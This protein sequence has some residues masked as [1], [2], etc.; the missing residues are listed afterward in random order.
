MSDATDAARD[1]V[2]KRAGELAADATPE[3]LKTIAEAV[4]QVHYGPQGAANTMRYDY[5]NET[6][7]HN[8]HHDGQRG[9]AGFGPPGDQPIPGEG[10]S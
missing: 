9:R 1:A 2:A 7:Y 10:S 6:N 8:F 5:H 3:S 4:A